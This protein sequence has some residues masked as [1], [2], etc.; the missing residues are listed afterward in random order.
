MKDEMKPAGLKGAY[1]VYKMLY[2]VDKL[3]VLPCLPVAIL[4][5]V[6]PYFAM[7]ATAFI[8]NGFIA[9]E[10]YR[11]LLTVALAASTA[12]FIFRIIQ[13]KIS[14]IQSLHN[15]IAVQ[16]VY[17]IKAE[18]YTTIDF[19]LLDGP[20]IH[21][22]NERIQRDSNWGGGFY[23]CSWFLNGT[24]ER[25]LGFIAGL[26]VLVG[27]L[28][29]NYV[30]GAVLFIICMMAFGA[31]MAYI[32]S[33][34]FAK[35]VNDF[36]NTGAK[37][38]ETDD[39]TD[40]ALNLSGYCL[41]GVE[42]GKLLK[43]ARLY[44]VNPMF[45]PYFEAVRRFRDRW[46]AKFA[47]LNLNAGMFS[48]L[49]HGIIAVAAYLFIVGSA[50]TGDIS[51][52]EVLLFVG[53]VHGMVNGFYSVSEVMHGLLDQCTRIQ[54]TLDFMEMPQVME[55]GTLPVEK[56][57]DNEYEIEFKNVS[58]KYPGSENYA[59]KNFN[60]N[61]RIGQKLAVVGLNGS[62]KTTMIK[63]LCRLYDPTEGE[64]TLN[65]IDVRK[66]DI[67]EYRDIFSVVFQDFKLLSLTIAQNLTCGKDR[68]DEHMN[69]VL[70][71]VGLGERMKT[72]ESGLDTYIYNDFEKG[73]EISGG[74]AQKIA[75][76]RAVYKNA[77]FILLDE[78][79]SAL[80]PIAEYEI[81]KDFNEITTDKTAIYISH[82][83]ASCRFCHDIAV[84]HEGSLIQRGNHDE[85][86]SDTSGKYHEL[87]HAQ[88]QYYNESA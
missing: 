32:T 75:L 5:S 31:F 47:R 52:G 77:P 72:M 33:A 45:K 69:E 39:Y 66:Y 80:D 12:A 15:G 3:A 58:F 63:L 44:N 83:L 28:T 16:K 65:G 38:M 19:Q 37:E 87:W 62:G 21:K 67:N 85:L 50:V 22:I 54:S 18:K 55:K 41:H 81:Y 9:G 8:L 29:R 74:E 7:F 2:D 46:T 60:M 27:L 40:A 13:N 6:T 51:V 42:V 11:L 25:L 30:S 20:Q 64:I 88:A 71:L 17:S 57:L 34:V 10:E 43:T 4:G 56:R 68:D 26:I 59:L 73:V 82:R 49:S 48:G 35:R 23:N 53:A 24:L 14:D 1:R 86:L 36:L 78:P 76:A 79:T 61:L 84:F 70:G